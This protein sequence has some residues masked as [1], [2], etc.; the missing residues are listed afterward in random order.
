MRAKTLGFAIAGMVL[1]VAGALAIR[2]GPAMTAAATILLINFDV[3]NGSSDRVTHTPVQGGPIPGDLYEPA[4]CPC[5]GLVLT[6]GV[7]PLPNDDPMVVRLATSLARA[8][9]VVLLPQQ[10]DLLAGRITEQ[11][12]DDLAG[13]V[14]W[15]QQSPVTAGRHVSVGGFSVGA[16]LMT[17]ATDRVT[18]PARGVFWFGGYG[19]ASTLLDSIACRRYQLDGRW[20]D[21]QP[22]E[23]AE[24]IATSQEVALPEAG[25]PACRQTQPSVVPDQRLRTI[26]PALTRSPARD[27]APLFALHDRGDAYVPFAETRRLVAAERSAR[28]PGSAPVHY[29]ETE[30]FDHVVPRSGFDLRT[31]RD[32]LQLA[33]LL[34]QFIENAR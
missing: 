22:S 1:V 34:T 14:T 17:M 29:V 19:D 3:I 2:W 4:G 26:S 13:A 30:L 25:D 15:L 10:P 11:A 5:P 20:M 33:V 21:W 32:G 27:R 31:V 12:I 6:L 28:P 8:G 24:E 7:S 18:Q 16:A 23:T 9:F